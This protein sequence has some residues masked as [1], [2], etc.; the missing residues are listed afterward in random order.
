MNSE[1]VSIVMATYNGEKFLRKQLES[2]LEQSYQH[3]ELIVV[4]DAST[5]KTLS[6]L[7]E[8]A[9]LYDRIHVFPAEKI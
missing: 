6:I 1:L 7:N 8:Y 3:Y 2:I 9:A 5:D 4:D